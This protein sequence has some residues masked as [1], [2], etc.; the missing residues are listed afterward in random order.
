LRDR[1]ES[2]NPHLA[3]RYA[4]GLEMVAIRLNVVGPRRNPM[5]RR[6]Q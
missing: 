4:A 3:V 1:V 2:I 5:P 6:E